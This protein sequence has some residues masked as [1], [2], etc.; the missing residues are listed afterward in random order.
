MWLS[1]HIPIYDSDIQSTE[2]AWRVEIG[3]RED[4]AVSVSRYGIYSVS[5]SCTELYFGSQRVRL[6]YVTKLE[7]KNSAPI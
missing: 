2:V 5:L 7:K 3:V 4:G 6:E 1:F